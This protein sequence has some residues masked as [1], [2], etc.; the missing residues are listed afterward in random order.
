MIDSTG[1]IE[2]VT[3]EEY[4]ATEVSVAVTF[5]GKV[6]EMSGRAAL[7]VVSG[8]EKNDCMVAGA[9]KAASLADM[10]G[11]ASEVL[12]DTAKKAGIAGSF[13]AA[14]LLGGSEGAGNEDHE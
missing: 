10:H 11:A 9:A 5:G 8:D 3:P 12:Y 7:V 6:T 13:V 4:A 2:C 1:T 14:V